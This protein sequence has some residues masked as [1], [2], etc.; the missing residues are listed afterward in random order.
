MAIIKGTTVKRVNKPMA[1][2]MEQ[3]NSAKTTNASVMVLPM[4]NKFT[5]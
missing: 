2:K 5:N 1:T 3:K 4:P